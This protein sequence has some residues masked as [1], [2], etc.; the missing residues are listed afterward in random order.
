MV[1][2]LRVALYL[3]ALGAMALL[4]SKSGSFWLDQAHATTGPGPTAATPAPGATAG[5]SSGSRTFSETGKTVEGIFLRYWT[6]NG[7]LPQQGFPI[8]SSMTEVSDLN[9]KSYTVQYFERAVFELHP[10]NAAPYNVL[11][12]QLDTFRYKEKYRTGVPSPSVNRTNPRLF[13]E[14]GHS[15]GGKF[16]GYWQAHGGLAQQGYPISDEFTEVSDLNGKSY[17]VQ[18]FERAVFEL[19]PE[20][21]APY[22]VLLSQLGTFRYNEKYRRPTGIAT[23]AAGFPTVTAGEPI[24][25]GIA[26]PTAT[27]APTEMPAA[28]AILPQPSGETAEVVMA[29]ADEHIVTPWGLAVDRAGNIYV[30]SKDYVLKFD[31]MGKLVLQFGSTGTGNGQFNFL[32]QNNPAYNCGA[33]AVDAASN[34]YLAD[35]GNSRVQKFDKDGRFLMAFGTKGPTEGQMLNP[36]D[37]AV[38]SQGSIYIVDDVNLGVRKYDS[39][40]NFRATLAGGSAAAVQVR[41]PVGLA[42]DRNDNVYVVDDKYN[43]VFKFGQDGHLLLKWGHLG[44]SSGAFDYTIDVTTDPAGNVFVVD[45]TRVQKF[46]ASGAWQMRWGSSGPGSGQFES[47]ASIATDGEGYIYVLDHTLNRVQKFKLK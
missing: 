3:S 47:P 45:N 17:T 22:D 16:L 29:I 39:N 5:Q 40:G 9:G 24:P 14:T 38:D 19:H 34:V 15:V 12:S 8:S 2:R 7:G 27:P 30:T 1:K 33:I 28:T 46:T 18:Y 41:E 32:C 35:S 43:S 36:I 13:P 21:A 10:E 11:L 31:A 25:T 44:T 4:A 37:I 23:P 42:V 6:N 26:Q 20:N